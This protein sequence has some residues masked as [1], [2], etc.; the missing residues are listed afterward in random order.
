M[1]QSGLSK[2]LFFLL[3]LASSLGAESFADFKTAQVK[4]FTKYADPRDNGYDAY[5]KEQF[6]EYRAYSGTALYE[7]PKP[8]IIEAAKP[9]RIDALGPK[10][11]I[12]LPEF[13]EIIQEKKPALSEEKQ[14]TVFDFYGSS[15]A[16]HINDKLKSANFHPQ[17]QAGIA[18]FFATMAASEYKTLL[19]DINAVKEE[20]EL[21]DWGLYLLVTELSHKAYEKEDDAK[22]FAWFLFNKLGYNAKV[23][24]AKQHIVLMLHSEK[25]IYDT[26]NFR[27]ADKKFYVLS[28]YA[29]TSSGSVYT[30][31]KSYPNAT[32]SLDLSLT[33]LPN[34]KENTKSKTLRFTHDGKVIELPYPYNQNLLDFM[35]SY[36]QAD[37]DTYFNAPLDAKTYGALAQGLK[38]EIDG[39]NSS[40]A[41]N[42]VLGFVQN[43]FIYEVDREQFGR[44]RV[45]FAQETLFFEKSDC[46]DRS[47]LFAALVKEL[48]K[49]GVIGVKYKN[50]M[51]TALYVPMQGDS[52]NAAGKRFVIADPTYINASIGQSMPKYRSQRP[53]SFIIVRSN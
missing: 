27:F 1:K 12:T 23:G 26:P 25:D 41:L 3:L 38:K 30:Y 51:A 16:F 8:K 32:K 31:E 7:E 18:A 2:N 15:L 44:E 28:E 50:H 21:N 48:F 33:Q 24:L 4:S 29:K 10:V 43:A 39:K 22:L 49:I 40:L 45:M 20:L 5:L 19:G 11:F 13:K 47:V 14:E 42:F 34:L 17:T 46:E 37:Y 6:K 35:A 52:V 53:E 9:E 36:P